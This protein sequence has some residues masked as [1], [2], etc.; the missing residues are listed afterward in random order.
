MQRP[1]P[2]PFI[3]PQRSTPAAGSFL[4]TR[5]DGPQVAR[6]APRAASLRYGP[7][8]CPRPRAGDSRSLRAACSARAQGRGVRRT[9]MCLPGVRRHSPALC[10]GPG[11][12]GWPSSASR[13]SPRTGGSASATRAFPGPFTFAAAL[14]ARAQCACRRAGD[15]PVLKDG[16]VLDC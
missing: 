6:G 15:A 4:L 11:P 10:C 12:P 14:R 7:P 8:R 5:G 3:Y 16:R 1:H 2:P 13:P 9:R